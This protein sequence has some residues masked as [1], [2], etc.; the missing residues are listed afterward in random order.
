MANTDLSVRSDPGLL[1]LW[2]DPTTTPAAAGA[3]PLLSDLEGE[4][5][6]DLLAAVNTVSAMWYPI[7]CTEAGSELASEI[8]TS[9]VP[10]AELLEPLRVDVTGVTHTLTFNAKERTCEVLSLAYSRL[11]Q[12]LDLAD[13]SKSLR[14][15]GASDKPTK[16][17]M[18]WAA[19]KRDPVSTR[20]LE[21]LQMPVVNPTG[22][23]TVSNGSLSETPGSV[24]LS[25]S[26]E[27]G[28]T[29]SYALE[30]WERLMSPTLCAA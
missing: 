20:P 24:P 19:L 27:R 12:F 26:L 28:Q 29:T 17:A 30:P 5:P 22:S 4:T 23:V 6:E 14:P 3:W 18:F 1:W 2:M 21:A 8:S 25:L 9:P 15:L 11:N 10:C 7:G 16:T 13:G